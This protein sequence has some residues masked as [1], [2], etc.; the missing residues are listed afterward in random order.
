MAKTKEMGGSP[1][2]TTKS[3]HDEGKHG[4]MKARL[5]TMDHTE[6]KQNNPPPLDKQFKRE[7]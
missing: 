3:F 1:K 6:G 4:H 7:K 5:P 2:G